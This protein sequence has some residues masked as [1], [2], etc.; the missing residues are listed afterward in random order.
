[1]DIHYPAYNEVKR[2]IWSYTSDVQDLLRD[3][4]GDKLLFNELNEVICEIED[5]QFDCTDELRELFGEDD[6]T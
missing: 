2:R 4:L 6:D 3:K 5:M 1:M